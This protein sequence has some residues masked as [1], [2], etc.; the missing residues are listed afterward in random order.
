M[1]TRY[2]FP[3]SYKKI[4]WVLLVIGLILGIILLLN[5]FEYPS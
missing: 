4:G 5:D 1:K 3:N 2:L